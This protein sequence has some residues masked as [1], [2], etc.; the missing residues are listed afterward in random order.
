MLSYANSYGMND[1]S[2]AQS[3]LAEWLKSKMN[4]HINKWMDERIN[5]KPCS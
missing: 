3:I 2:V 1:I 5:N 4:R